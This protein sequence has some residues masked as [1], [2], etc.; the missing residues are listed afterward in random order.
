VVDA[1]VTEPVDE[2]L[3]THAPTRLEVLDGPDAGLT[4][5]LSHPTVVVGA[6]PDCDVQL[7]DPTVSRRH[8]E[9]RIDPSGLHV[10][11]LGSTNGTWAG[12]L[13]IRE[14]YVDPGSIIEVGTTRFRLTGGE[15]LGDSGRRLITESS[16]MRMLLSR[17]ERVASSSCT[18]LLLGETGTGKELVAETI[19]RGSPRARG[20][21]VVLDC[22]ALPASLADSEIFG[23]VRGA[24]TGAVDGH[25]GAFESADGGTLFLDDVG[26]LPLD[27]QPKLLRTL[28]RPFIQRVGS[29]TV[30]PVDVRVIAATHLDLAASVRNGR[31]REDLFHRLHVVPLTVP[32]LRERR[33][34]LPGLVEQFLGRHP[35][36]SRILS[37]QAWAFLTRHDWPGNVRELRNVLERYAVFTPAR[38]P[39]GTIPD[40]PA[41]ASSPPEVGPNLLDVV[42]DP[43][44]PFKEAKQD[45]VDRFERA[46]L[47]QLLVRHGWNLSAAARAARLDRMSIY[48]ML[49]RHNVSRVRED[50]EPE[51]EQPAECVP[52]DPHLRDR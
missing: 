38:A 29:S 50:K 22:A 48:N 52:R 35:R 37:E 3:L 46:Y 34:D 16:A 41:L 47:E 4:F 15:A 14:A 18:V 36:G 51:V 1:R 6:H 31:F 17:L 45:V 2:S 21:F 42:V 32:P 13:R 26:E 40:R 39:L 11:D 12:G 43:S 27:V 25:A 24:F 30:I 20:P 44:F 49:E 10:R 9:I 5:E 28:T 23:H 7:R 8:L 33:E 19:H